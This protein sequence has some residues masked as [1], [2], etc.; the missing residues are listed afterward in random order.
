MPSYAF[1]Q[2]KYIDIFVDGHLYS[3]HFCQIIFNSDNNFHRRRGLKFL[4]KVHKGNWPHTMAAN[5][6]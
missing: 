5:V 6:F 1:R 4:I 2:I 3:D